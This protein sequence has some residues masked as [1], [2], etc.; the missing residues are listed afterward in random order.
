MRE[1]KNAADQAHVLLHV[2]GPRNLDELNAA[3]ADVANARPDALL[4]TAEAFTRQH[5]ARILDFAN[6]NKVPTMFED[7]SYVAA[8]GLM[9]YG[10]DYQDVFR[11]AAIFVDKILKG[12]KPGRVADRAADEVRTCDQ[13]QGRNGTWT[14]NSAKAACV[15]RQGDRVTLLA[16]PGPANRRV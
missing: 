4:V 1:T 11:K 16:L 8:G 12:A 3:L 9:S 10:P 2:V 15:S 5:Q 13:P 7:S 14:R 6:S